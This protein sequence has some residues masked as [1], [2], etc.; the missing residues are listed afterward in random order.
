MSEFIENYKSGIDEAS[1]RSDFPEITDSEVPIW[2]GTPSFLSMADKYILATLVFLVHL[3][4]FLGGTLDAPEGDGRANAI[5]AIALWLV[6]VTGVMGFVVAMLL[7]TKINHYANFSTSGA[8]TTTWLLVSAL[9]P[10]VWKLLDIV[11]WASGFAGSEFDNPLPDWLFVWFL[12]LGAISFSVMLVF[13]LLYQRAF[14]YAITDRRV[15][16]RKSFLYIDSSVHGIA[17]EKVENLKADPTILGRL[18]GF[19][20]VHILTGSGMG[21]QGETV[22][23]NLGV[24]GEAPA[25]V[26][27]VV[28]RLLSLLFVWIT[29]QRQRTVLAKDPAD[30]LYGVRDPMGIYRLINELMDVNAGP[31]GAVQLDIEHV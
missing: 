29:M 17:F 18:L 11:S 26:P 1:T 3:L 9:I 15:H 7:L 20:N 8:W 25:A 6:D 2:R 13:T 24:A 22:G 4:F 12:P 23:M 30:C 31:V 16:I 27:S 14:Q 28:K 21:L 10:F 5:I 19:G